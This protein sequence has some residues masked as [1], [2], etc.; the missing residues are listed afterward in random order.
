MKV[1]RRSF[2]TLAAGLAPATALAGSR[3][4]LYLPPANGS[5]HSELFLPG[6]SAPGLAAA[7]Y[8]LS[9]LDL[10]RSIVEGSGDC[11]IRILFEFGCP[12]SPELYRRIRPML[13]SAKYAWIPIPTMVMGKNRSAPP[14]VRS[15]DPAVALFAP[16]AGP[17]SL[18]DVFDGKPPAR[19]DSAAAARQAL[20]FKRKIEPEIFLETSRPFVTPTLVY[21]GRDAETRVIR[22]SPDLGTLRTIIASAQP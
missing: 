11:R 18:K 12:R 7:P 10:M 20:L 8:L 16:Q 6:S 2:L 1:S 21:R 3:E 14:S 4:E 15:D 22:G 13:T 9:D 17:E 19:S 5:E